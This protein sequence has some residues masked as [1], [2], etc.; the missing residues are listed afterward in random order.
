M[1]I[2]FHPLVLLPVKLKK[3]STHGENDA[4]VKM[5]GSALEDATSRCISAVEGM[6]ML[7]ETNLLD[8]AVTVGSTKH[9]VKPN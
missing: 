2:T 7:I 1:C 4:Y 8:V 9:L 6:V 5:V 3:L